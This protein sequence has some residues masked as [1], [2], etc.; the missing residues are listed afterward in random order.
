MSTAFA[1][2]DWIAIGDDTPDEGDQVLIMADEI[3][4]PISVYWRKE[5][6]GDK[7]TP[8]VSDSP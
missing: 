8:L 1:V 5:L 3:E 7:V 6:Y 4:L 2:W